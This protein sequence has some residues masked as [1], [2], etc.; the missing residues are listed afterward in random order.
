[1][2]DHIIRG[3]LGPNHYYSAGIDVAAAEIDVRA[4]GWIR[5]II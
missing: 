5:Y 1:L 3:T 2:S 4:F